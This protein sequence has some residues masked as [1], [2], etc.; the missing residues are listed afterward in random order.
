ML[1]DTSMIVQLGVGFYRL[2][3]SVYGAC[4]CV[5]ASLRAARYA[6]LDSGYIVR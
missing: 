6:W 5:S 2:L 4:S 3:A 1:V